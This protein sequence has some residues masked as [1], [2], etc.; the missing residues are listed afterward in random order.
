MIE[1]LDKRLRDSYFPKGSFQHR[2]AELV[3]IFPFV[4]TTVSSTEERELETYLGICG[5]VARKIAG[6]KKST[7][8]GIDDLK[9]S[10]QDKVE[11]NEPDH[12]LDILKA[13]EAGKNPWEPWHDRLPSSYFEKRWGAA[14][15]DTNKV[16]WET[17]KA[18]LK[19]RQLASKKD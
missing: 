4:T 14:W 18:S 10:L 1:D 8:F 7:P 6:L 3:R 12:L 16:F 9:A 19:S 11:T 13:K 17:F 5:V 15:K 2:K